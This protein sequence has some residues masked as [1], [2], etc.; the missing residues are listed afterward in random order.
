MAV[1][2]TEPETTPVRAET[3]LLVAALA[4][5]YV[6]W[7]STYLAV[8]FMV[9]EIPAVLGSGTRALAA[10]GLMAVGVGRVGRRTEAA[11]DPGRARRLRAARSADAGARVR[12]S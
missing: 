1:L 4:T 5:V 11:G 10:G 8:R 9:D 6:A 12:A 2:T 7:G 3:S